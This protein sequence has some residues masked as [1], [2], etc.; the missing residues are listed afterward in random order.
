[1]VKKK[2]ALEQD[3]S[4]K[5]KP[6]IKL[7]EADETLAAEIVAESEERRENSNLTPKIFPIVCR[8][9]EV[10]DE[11][12]GDKKMVTAEGHTPIHRVSKQDVKNVKRCP[13][14]QALYTKMS[15][16]KDVRRMKA[17]LVSVIEAGMAAEGIINDPPEDLTA[18]D[19]RDLSHSVSRM[20]E[21]KALLN[22]MTEV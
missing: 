5:A 17:R 4:R 2:T 13:P 16:N 12:T 7:S 18:D 1:M 22:K 19:K 11:N 10:T 15:R 6:P 3:R 21:A 8:G 9:V 20:K 14:C